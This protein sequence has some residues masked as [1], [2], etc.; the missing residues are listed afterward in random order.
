MDRA[1][2]N[3]E[4]RLQ[5]LDAQVKNLTRL[6]YSDHHAIIVLLT[7]HTI[8]NFLKI[9]KFDYNTCYYHLKVVQRRRRKAIHFIRDVQGICI[10]DPNEIRSMFK[11][12][13]L[14]LYTTYVEV[15][16]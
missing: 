12:S 8:T 2:S 6:K 7:Y 1:M 9:F 14:H 11:K 15:D 4:W 3:D 5:F 10:H 13:Y 16:S